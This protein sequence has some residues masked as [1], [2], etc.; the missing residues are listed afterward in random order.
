MQASDIPVKTPLGVN[1]LSLNGSGLPSLMHSLLRVIDGRLPVSKYVALL[2]KY[3]DVALMIDTLE[4]LGM[5]TTREA[6]QGKL[7]APKPPPPAQKPAAPTRASGTDPLVVR[8]RLLD[9]IN[10]RLGMD[11]LDLM[12]QVESAR[13][14]TSL[15]ATRAAA[16][17]AFQKSGLDWAAARELYASLQT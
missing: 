13:D 1:E 16:Q 15:L 8:A 5:V 12:L 9:L 3:G 6:G 17:A 7:A 10:S 4:Q 14:A 11:A 2:P